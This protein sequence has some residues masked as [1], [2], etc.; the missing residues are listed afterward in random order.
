VNF[1][2][3]RFPH[4]IEKPLDFAALIFL[5]DRIIKALELSR[6]SPGSGVRATQER[7]GQGREK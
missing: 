5:D 6:S 3:P 2:S 1:S 4:P 7:N